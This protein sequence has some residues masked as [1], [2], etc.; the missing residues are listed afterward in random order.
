MSYAAWLG[1]NVA[2]MQSEIVALRAEVQAYRELP[3]VTPE[4]H[5]L[6][7]DARDRALAELASVTKERDALVAKRLDTGTL[8]D[9]MRARYGREAR[10]WEANH[11]ERK[12]E[13]DEA[14]AERDGCAATAGHWMRKHGEV[15]D[16]RDRA[17]A[18]LDVSTREAARY[19]TQLD[20]Y[21]VLVDS[22]TREIADARDKRGAVALKRALRLLQDVMHRLRS[23]TGAPKEN[24]LH[25]EARAFLAEHGCRCVDEGMDKANEQW[26]AGEGRR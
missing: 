8:A 5:R 14:I 24:A 11:A 10:Q 22:M 23:Y 13:R 18:E 21:A 4:A 25:A 3:L 2:D 15:S 12:K 17:L 1:A 6:A 16:A 7:C 19:R 20:E 9:V 26:L